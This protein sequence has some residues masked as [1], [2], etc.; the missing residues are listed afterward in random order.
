MIKN[1]TNRIVCTLAVMAALIVA[2]PAVYAD[3]PSVVYQRV[4]TEFGYTQ[5][6]DIVVDDAGSAGP[7]NKGAPSC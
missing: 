5:P 3:E 1:H 6:H 4:F 7:A 2:A